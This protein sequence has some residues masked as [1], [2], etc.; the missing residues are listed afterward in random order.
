MFANKIILLSSMIMQIVSTT[1]KEVVD[2][3]G[4][5]SDFSNL[6]FWS[7]Q[8]WLRKRE[9]NSSSPMKEISSGIRLKVQSI[10]ISP[11]L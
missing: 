1:T 7:C 2:G 9:L 4:G 8:M 6:M 11:M 10:G 3:D 5:T